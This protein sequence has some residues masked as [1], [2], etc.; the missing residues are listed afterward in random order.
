MERAIA[1]DEAWLLAAGWD[2]FM[3]FRFALRCL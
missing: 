3:A 1:A 2:P